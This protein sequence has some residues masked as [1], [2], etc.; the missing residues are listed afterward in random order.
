VIFFVYPLLTGLISFFEDGQIQISEAGKELL[1]QPL[2]IIP[3]ML[4]LF[5]FG[6]FPEELG[7]RRY[8]LDGLQDRMN[9]VAASL[10]LGTIWAFWHFPLFLM[11]GTYQHELGLGSAAFWQFII[12]A[13]LISVF[14][15]WIYNNNQNSILSASLFHFSVNLTGNVLLETGV[16]Q[17]TRIAVLVVLAFL[18]VFFTKQNGLLGFIE[19]NELPNPHST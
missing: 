4:F 10:L 12:S 6:P 8:A 5:I 18:L 11:Q 15:T 19:Q 3:F 16:L 2:R 9:P 13:I 14:F 1:I 7:W 17:T